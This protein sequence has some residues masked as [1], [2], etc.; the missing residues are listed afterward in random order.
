M[1]VEVH[2]GNTIIRGDEYKVLK[3]LGKGSLLYKKRQKKR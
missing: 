2:L 1:R 3:V